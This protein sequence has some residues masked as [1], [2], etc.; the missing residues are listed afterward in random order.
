MLTKRHFYLSIFISLL[1]VSS[2]GNL[3]F[4]Q[5]P[6]KWAISVNIPNYSDNGSPP[7]LIA[8]Q[9]Q[10]VHVFY[11]DTFDGASVVMYRQWTLENGWTKPL[12]I[13]IGTISITGLLVD[14]N[15]TLH[16]TFF[17]GTEVDGNIYYMSGDLAGLAQ[18]QGAR[19]WSTPQ[20]IAGN[21][22]PFGHGAS[23][24]D[25]QGNIYSLYG[26]REDGN[27]LYS[28]YSTDYGKNWSTPETVFLTYSD[29]A[30]PTVPNVISDSNGNVHAVWSVW[31]TAGVGEEILYASMDAD[32]KQW[33][34]PIQLAK[35][36][37]GDYEAD[38]PSIVEHN[39][40]LI[41]IY[42]D[43]FPATK[44]MRRSRDN[45]LTWSNPVR[46]WDHIGEYGA[47]VFLKDGDDTLHIILGNRLNDLSHGMWHGVWLE[48]GWSQLEPIVTGPK[49]NQFDP[50]RPSAVIVQG[51]VL[52]ATWDMD[53]AK[54]DNGIWYSY[55]TLDAT[56]LS[57][58]PLPTLAPPTAIP[59]VAATEEPA[60]P[61]PVR[62]A[63]DLSQIK[64]PSSNSYSNN[65]SFPL[66]LSLIPVALILA[67]VFVVI[68][69]NHR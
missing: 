11:G 20:L 65:P 58:K 2:T 33:S 59:T 37:E 47:P 69:L 68:R 6:N 50:T 62:Q 52:L 61:T 57:L 67:I 10:T 53:S 17:K 19:V 64:E 38:W 56:E 41:V 44:F 26:G 28:I 45:G 60:T 34:T 16:M 14:E 24:I 13:Y 66:S 42:Q 46:P 31:S 27:G 63:V 48:D 7:T 40:E 35:R 54:P 22:G 9:N 39:G 51:N 43:D 3:A 4:A 15:N 29:E 25:K 21:A 30:W 12:D 18:G 49:T 55:T 1:I 36:D 32:T 8:D 23:T 5:E